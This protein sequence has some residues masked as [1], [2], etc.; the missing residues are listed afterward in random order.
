MPIEVQSLAEIRRLPE[1]IFKEIA[2]AVTGAAF[3]VHNRFGR[4]FGENVYKFELAAECCKRGL[5]DVEVE[6][7]IRLS[8]NDFNKL[9]FMDLL[10]HGGAVFELKVADALNEEHVNQTLNYLCLADLNRAK[11]LTFGSD[12]VQDRFVSTTLTLTE[13]QR[14]RLNLD[15]WQ[16]ESTEDDRFRELM[17]LL[18]DEWGGFLS[19]PVY[20]DAITH[21]FGGEERVV[22]P[23]PVIR[24][25]REIGV[26]PAH[27]LGPDTAFKITALPDQL[28]PAEEHLRRFLHHTTLRRIQWVNLFHHDV[29]F[30]SLTD[31]V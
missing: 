25:G 6:V 4:F 29:Q 1:D 17:I 20:Q 18:L 14:Y 27:L 15:R 7:P 26:Q 2:F 31:E 24:D 11:L 10:V 12:R 16:P 3:D 19:I 21:F 22:Q 5:P 23:V 30:I 9:Y 28:I 8:L 13:R